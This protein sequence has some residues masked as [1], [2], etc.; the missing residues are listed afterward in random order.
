MPLQHLP[1]LSSSQEAPVLHLL[2][3]RPHTSSSTIGSSSFRIDCCWLPVGP[4][5]VNLH[6]ALDQLVSR[7]STRLDHHPFGS[8]WRPLDFISR[9]LRVYRR[10]CILGYSVF[11][12]AS[13]LLQD[14]P[15]R[16]DPPAAPG[17]TTQHQLSCWSSVAVITAIVGLAE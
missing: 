7:P 4:C 8:R 12:A 6:R 13:A 16:W 15:S 1:Q 10:R 9:H 17:H 11:L 3:P 2:L 5:H 14:R